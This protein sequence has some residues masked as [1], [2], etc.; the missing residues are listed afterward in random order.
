L[1]NIFFLQVI[2]A[3]RLLITVDVLIVRGG[4]IKAIAL[5]MLHLNVI[6]ITAFT[7]NYNQCVHGLVPG[8]K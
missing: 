2:L 3:G 4:N 1:L 8:S 5:V 7:V 6:I